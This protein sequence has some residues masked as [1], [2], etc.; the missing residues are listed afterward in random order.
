VRRQLVLG[1][2][3][4]AVMHQVRQHAELMAREAQRLP[5][6]CCARRSRIQHEIAALEKRCRLTAGAS[7]ERA[8]A[9]E[10]FFNLKGFRD[11]I[12][13]A[14]VDAQHLL[15]PAGARRQNQH[16]HGE[17]LIA[18][19]AQRAE[20]VE[21]RQAQVE[22]DG[23]IVRGPRQK[24]RALS[25]FG[26]VHGVPCGL[27]RPGQLPRDP[28]FIFGNQDPHRDLI[29]GTSG[30]QVLGFSGSSGSSFDTGGR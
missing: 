27:Q 17:A 13:G 15:V 28:Q 21:T 5:C 14:A 2:H 23:I 4:V 25:I 7:D 11:V 10:H 19:A 16:G 26:R 20:T 22:H 1:H 3:A 30:P 6:D 9:R 12:V 8:Q 18:P 29:A 24:I